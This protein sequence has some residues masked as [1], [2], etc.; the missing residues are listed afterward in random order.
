MKDFAFPILVVLAIIVIALTGGIKM[1]PLVPANNAT[2]T[3]QSTAGPGPSEH[4]MTQNEIAWKLQDAQ[5]QL[6]QLQQQVA[7]EQEAKISSKYKGQITMM[8]GGWSGTDPD[9]EYIEIDANY[10]NTSPINISGWTLTSTSTGQTLIIPQS[11]NLYLSNAQNTDENVILAPGERVYIVTGKSPIGYGFHANICSGYLSQFHTFTPGMFTQC[12]A[13][14]DEPAVISIPRTTSNNNCFDLID[15]LPSCQVYTQTMYN[16]YSQQCQDFVQTKLNYQACV[17]TH[18]NDANFWSPK[19][20]YVYL[21][22]DTVLW[23][24]RRETVVLT[25]TAGKTVYKMSR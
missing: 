10:G 2:S 14:R 15:S 12:P 25:D 22:R 9:Q 8:W 23:Q 18:R 11:T 6:Q 3:Y 1:E 5:Y 17:D 24:P 16:T 20:W 7:D 4:Q 21:K 13:P 19:I